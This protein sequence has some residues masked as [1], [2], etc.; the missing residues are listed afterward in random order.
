MRYHLDRRSVLWRYGLALLAVAAALL[1][2]LAA[3]QFGLAN[4][5]AAFLAAILLTGWYAGIGPLIAAMVLS[6][7]VYDYF[8]L[9]PLYTLGLRWGPDPYLVW[10][11]LFGLLAAGPDGRAQAE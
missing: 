5:S 6:T 4:R 7:F 2:T 9:P 10:F 1:V 11:L 8:F 3:Q